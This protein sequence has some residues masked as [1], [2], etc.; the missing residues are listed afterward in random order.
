MG[1][2]AVGDT[3][4]VAAGMTSTAAVA[5]AATNNADLAAAG[6]A[7]RG[8]GIDGDDAPN[9][10]N[11][12]TNT[13]N[14]TNNN[15]NHDINDQE[16]ARKKQVCREALTAMVAALGPLE[17]ASITLTTLLFLFLPMNPNEYDGEPIPASHIISIW[18]I[19]IVFETLLP[20]SFIACFR[21][22]RGGVRGGEGKG[23]ACEMSPLA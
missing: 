2:D 16:V 11:T 14:T 3:A 8:A 5:T 18:A 1:V 17:G 19:A 22:G 23:G 9:T 15:T 20:E 21:S 7:H 6:A 10:T 13:T 12:T 4:T